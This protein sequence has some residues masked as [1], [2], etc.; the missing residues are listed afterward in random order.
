[1]GIEPL[2]MFLELYIGEH[3]MPADICRVHFGVMHFNA[4]Y[5]AAVCCVD[6]SLQK[7]WSCSW[8]CLYSCSG[9]HA[10]ALK[11]IMVCM[12]ACMQLVEHTS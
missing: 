8:S 11:E 3:C 9:A 10:L 5:K 1:M 7:R 4:V 6:V 12:V 2:V